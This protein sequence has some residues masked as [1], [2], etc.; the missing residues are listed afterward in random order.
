MEEH[1]D[2]CFSSRL[3]GYPNIASHVH[4]M[5]RVLGLEYRTSLN[6][7]SSPHDQTRVVFNLLICQSS[8]QSQLELPCVHR[9]NRTS[10]PRQNSCTI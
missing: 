10:F 6:V 5:E 4:R 8:G 1:H 7:S 3:I 2:E 9:W